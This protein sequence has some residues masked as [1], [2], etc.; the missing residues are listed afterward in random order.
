M[1]Y[2][3]F[4]GVTEFRQRFNPAIPQMMLIP[5]PLGQEYGCS[6]F[7]VEHGPGKSILFMGSLVVS[8]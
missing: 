3:F 5:E 1:N 8:W 4:G 7:I 6:W 2:P